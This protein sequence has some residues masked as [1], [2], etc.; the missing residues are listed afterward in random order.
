MRQGPTHRLIAF[1]AAQELSIPDRRQRLVSIVPSATSPTPAAQPAASGA[2]QVPTIKSRDR[3]RRPRA[4][5]V[6]KGLI[7]GLLQPFASSV[8]L[9]NLAHLKAALSTRARSA[10]QVHTPTAAAHLLAL[11]VRPEQRATSLGPQVTR[12]ARPAIRE[13]SQ[14]LLGRSRVSLA[15]WEH[16]KTRAASRAARYARPGAP[17]RR[18]DQHHATSA[19]QAHTL[20]MTEWIGVCSAPRAH[21]SFSLGE[22]TAQTAR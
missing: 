13:P 15:T 14:T 4:R 1:L 16:I 12:T 22:R 3:I 17:H 11:P 9:E 8:L 5:S 10:L 6:S 18:L 19:N 7:R 20:P 21:S 2:Q